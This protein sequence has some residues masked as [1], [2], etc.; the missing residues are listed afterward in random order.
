M[1]CS[2][3]AL[4]EGCECRNARAR[5]PRVFLA[6]IHCEMTRQAG[7]VYLESLQLRCNSATVQQYIAQSIAYRGR[8]A[9]SICATFALFVSRP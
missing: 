1:T 6:V 7:V 5:S 4:E 9:A 3:G 2:S 8:L